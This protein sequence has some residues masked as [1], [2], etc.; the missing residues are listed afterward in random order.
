MTIWQHIYIYIYTH[1]HTH[2]THARTQCPACSKWEVRFRPSY[3]HMLR[4]SPEASS[5]TS[6]GNQAHLP[7][8][9]QVAFFTNL[10]GRRCCFKSI[11]QGVATYESHNGA[12]RQAREQDQNM[13]SV[14][15][16]ACIKHITEMAVAQKA[17][18][19]QHGLPWNLESQK[20]WT[21]QNL[22]FG[23]SAPPIGFMLVATRQKSLIEGASTTRCGESPPKRNSLLRP[24]F[25]NWRAAPRGREA[26]RMQRNT[27]RRTDHGPF[28]ENS[29]QATV[30][31]YGA[32][33]CARR[34]NQT[35]GHI[36]FS[37]I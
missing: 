26:I 32:F 20:T 21:F 18:K 1:T 22:R 4:T 7:F 27:Q 13:D 30:L 12:C 35:M 23:N 2:A 36:L 8:T 28:F 37:L 6:E 29:D 14:V 19:F 33:Y 15:C 9:I 31:F 16:G 34:T 25:W 24:S 17:G 10:G 11:S 3:E 5:E